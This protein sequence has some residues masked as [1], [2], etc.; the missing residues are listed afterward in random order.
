MCVQNTNR[1]C[2]DMNLKR[3]TVR[4]ILAIVTF[5]VGAGLCDSSVDGNHYEF[6]GSSYGLDDSGSYYIS[7]VAQSHNNIINDLCL[8]VG[9]VKEELMRDAQPSSEGGPSVTK[10]L[11]A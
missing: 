3:T 9:N 8:H 7:K 2:V 6:D 1:G 4:S 11:K 10:I 5:C